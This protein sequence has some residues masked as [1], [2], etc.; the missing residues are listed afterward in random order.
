MIFDRLEQA[1]KPTPYKHLM[2]GVFGGQNCIQLICKE[3]KTAKENYEDFY[4]LSLDVKHSKT[5]YESLQRHIQDDT[6]NDYHCDT[7]DKRVDI[8]KRTVLNSVPN[9]LI[10]HLQRLVFNFD[11]LTNEKINSR[12][13]FPHV[14]NLLEYT[15]Q[16]IEQKEKIEQG[17]EDIP[18]ID[19]SDYEYELVGIIVHTGTA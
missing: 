5:L 7:C 8:T 14:L 12:L 15:K 11:T 4:N 1:L 17:E 16:G 6:I 18:Y 10:V 19:K 3:C 9:M 13:E 2:Q